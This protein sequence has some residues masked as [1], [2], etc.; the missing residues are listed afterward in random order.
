[1]SDTDLKALGDAA[2]HEGFHDFGN[3][4]LE[5]AD[6]IE[7][8]ERALQGIADCDCEG[9]QPQARGLARIAREA[10]NHD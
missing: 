4:L 10:L 9:S 7:A 6:R 2:V 1:M 3:A 5:A 8:L